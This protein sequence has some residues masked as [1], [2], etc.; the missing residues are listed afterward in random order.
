M[1]EHLPIE[2]NKDGFKLI[3]TNMIIADNEMLLEYKNKKDIAINLTKYYGG[4]FGNNNGIPYNLR[5]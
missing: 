4:A 1:L 5:S 3:G 2:E